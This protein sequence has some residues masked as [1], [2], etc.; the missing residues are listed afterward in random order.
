MSAAELARLAGCTPD[1]VMATAAALGIAP[2][3]T[4]A[5]GGIFVDRFL[6]DE[7]NAIYRALRAAR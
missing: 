4:R 6:G 2:T 3:P 7:P 5:L 1:D